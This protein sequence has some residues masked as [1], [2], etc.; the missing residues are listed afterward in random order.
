MDLFGQGRGREENRAKQL[1]SIVTS[2]YEKDELYHLC[3]TYR[4]KLK[5]SSFSLETPKLDGHMKRRLKGKRSFD[6]S[7]AQIRE[8]NLVTIQEKLLGI[9]N[10]LVFLWGA[11]CTQSEDVSLTCNTVVVAMKQWEHFFQFLTTQRRR[12]Y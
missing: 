1:R 4:P 12:T 11:A 6:A 8:K 3:N 9:I 10:P 7:R 5:L 2:R